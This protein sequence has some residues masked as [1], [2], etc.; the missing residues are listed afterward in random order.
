MRQQSEFTCNCA[1]EG[2][3][4]SF[5]KRKKKKKQ[6]TLFYLFAGLCNNRKDDI[7]V[8]YFGSFH[9]IVSLTLVMEIITPATLF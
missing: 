4:L 2:L 9:E 8:F 1:P 3:Q 6:Y 7:S 5:K